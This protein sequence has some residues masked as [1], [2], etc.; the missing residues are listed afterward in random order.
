MAAKSIS[1]AALQILEE[2]GVID[3]PKDW[4]VIRVESLLSDDRGISVGV[5][6]PG[7]HDPAG[8]PLIKAGDLAGSRINPRPEF[9]ITLD[10][11]REYRRTELAGGELLISLVGDVGRCA[12]VPP[13][14]A[15]WNAARAIAVLRLKEPE[16]AA[17]VHRVLDEFA[18]PT[19]DAGMVY[20]DCAGDPES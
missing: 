9:R 5:M 14:M 15:G 2:I 7:E 13:V 20:H 10:K 3:L 16:D 1:P 19:S 11:H 8:V 12:V 18:F 17:F 4:D 6:Y